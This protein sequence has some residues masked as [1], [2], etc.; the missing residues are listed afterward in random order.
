[1]QTYNTSRY[2]LYHNNLVDIILQ[3]FLNLLEC[4]A[5]IER[6]GAMGRIYIVCLEEENNPDVL[7]SIMTYAVLF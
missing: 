6:R 2:L 5:F 3:L 4:F 1:M 7:S